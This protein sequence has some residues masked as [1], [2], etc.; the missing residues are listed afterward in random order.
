MSRALTIATFGVTTLAA[1][2]GAQTVNR[3][4]SAAG[5]G[6]LQ[7]HFAARQGVC[8]NGR[9]FFRASEAGYYSTYTNGSNDESCTAGPIRAVIVRSGREIVKIETYAG[10]LSTEPDGGMD[11]GAVPAADAASYLL[12]LAMS[13]EGR[14]AREAMLPA[15]LADSAVVTPQLTQLVRDQA[16]SRDIRGSALSWLARRRGETGG[17]GAPV[18]QR[19]LETIVHDQNEGEGIRSQALSMLGN[20]DR[21]EGIPLLIAL[22]GDSDGWVSRQAFAAI[23]RSGDPRARQFVRQAIHRSELPEESR[24]AAIRGI[25]NEYA[26]AG[27]YKLLR[28]LYPS[29]NSDPER[30]AIISSIAT[31]GGSENV[32]WLLSLAK[33]PTEPAQR[34][35]Q[36]VNALSRNDDPRVKDALK[37]LIEKE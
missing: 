23:A 21:G 36:A 18:A 22:S 3:L 29:V 2:A 33:S 25:G 9:S 1:C 32:N 6:T 35:R 24:A 11:L 31:A 15:M 4:V 30:S 8:G 27:D 12:G 19:T 26:V 37:G 20:L 7:F 16:R 28:D 34:R 5:D 13:L 10:P 17:V 14:P